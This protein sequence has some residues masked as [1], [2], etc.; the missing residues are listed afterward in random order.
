MTREEVDY[1]KSQ[2][3]T[4]RNDYFF[5]GK[6]GGRRKYPIFLQ[7]KE[8]MPKRVILNVELFLDK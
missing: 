8:Y 3:A 1:V 2:N 6:D 7:N 5:E 4:S